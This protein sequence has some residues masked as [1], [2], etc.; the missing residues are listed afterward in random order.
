MFDKE[1]S[2]YI[3]QKYAT[4]WYVR[5]IKTGKLEKDSPFKLEKR[6]S[7]ITIKELSIYLKMPPSEDEQLIKDILN[8]EALAKSYK[9]D[10]Q[11]S[12]RNC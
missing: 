4:G 7:N 9:D 10:L 2:R 5:I 12:L 1:T 3:S 6:V 8:T 11:N